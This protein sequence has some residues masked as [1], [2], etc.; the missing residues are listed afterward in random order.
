[1]IQSI[2]AHFHSLPFYKSGPRQPT[3][4]KRT[5]ASGTVKPVY[6]I[7]RISCRGCL[8]WNCYR[9]V[10]R[11]GGYI[12]VLGLETSRE[13]KCQTYSMHDVNKFLECVLGIGL[14]AFE[15]NINQVFSVLE[16]ILDSVDL[17]F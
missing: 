9:T 5:P 16:M 14:I 7:E 4:S 8:L 17:Y 2:H 11:V 13:Y 6:V 3:G 1:M 12:G 15:K 10:S